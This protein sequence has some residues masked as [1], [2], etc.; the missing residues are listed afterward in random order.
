M[1]ETPQSLFMVVL[2]HK[3]NK[4]FLKAFAFMTADRY[5]SSIYLNK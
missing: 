5:I 2:S 3:N 1:L 4:Y